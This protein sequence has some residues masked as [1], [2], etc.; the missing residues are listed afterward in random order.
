MDE[1]K[2]Y[3]LESANWASHTK[4][5]NVSQRPVVIVR[6]EKRPRWPIYKKLKTIFIFKFDKTIFSKVISNKLKTVL[7]VSVSSQQTAYIWKKKNNFIGE[8]VGLILV[9]QGSL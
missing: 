7:P 5:L 1:L 8:T 4:V 6:W 3:L 2:I 9:L